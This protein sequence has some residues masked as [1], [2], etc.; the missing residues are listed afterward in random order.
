M[1]YGKSLSN[2]RMKE[3]MHFLASAKEVAEAKCHFPAKLSWRCSTNLTSVSFVA[4]TVLVL[5]FS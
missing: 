1:F 4:S 5:L 2:R 3:M